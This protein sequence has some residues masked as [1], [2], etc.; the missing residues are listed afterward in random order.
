MEFC[1]KKIS[2]VACP[3]PGKVGLPEWWKTGLEIK[4]VLINWIN[5]LGG[6]KK[7]SG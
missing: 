6:K 7:K 5:D 4:M 1:F 2:A 3:A